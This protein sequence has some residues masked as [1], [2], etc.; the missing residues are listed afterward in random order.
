MHSS[1]AFLSLEKEKDTVYMKYDTLIIYA[2]HSSID[3]IFCRL[4]IP[5]LKRC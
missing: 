3:G 1:D 2:Q 4:S 5:H